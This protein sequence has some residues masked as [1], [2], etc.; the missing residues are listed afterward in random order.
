MPSKASDEIKCEATLKEISSHTVSVSFP[1]PME[2]RATVAVEQMS[3]IESL[4]TL[5]SRLVSAID[6][7]GADLQQ[8]TAYF[9]PLAVD[10]ATLLKGATVAADLLKRELASERPRFDVIRL[11]AY[12]IKWLATKGDIFVTA[13][14]TSAGGQIGME[15]A[16]KLLQ[17]DLPTAMAQLE[18]WMQIHNLPF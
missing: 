9:D 14:L 17:T 15:L 1:I 2:R 7:I 12:V 8:L 4:A 18:H 5:T 13:V 16:N 10:T 6:T 3:P 11:C